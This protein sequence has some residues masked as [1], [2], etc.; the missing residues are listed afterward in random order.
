MKKRKKKKK[1]KKKKR[2]PKLRP[3]ALNWVM[4]TSIETMLPSS[5]NGRSYDSVSCNGIIGAASCSMTAELNAVVAHPHRIH[6]CRT[7][8]WILIRKKV[9]VTFSFRTLRPEQKHAFNYKVKK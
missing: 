5:S 2:L 9:K 6:A 4:N 3:F 7:R 8:T 1:K